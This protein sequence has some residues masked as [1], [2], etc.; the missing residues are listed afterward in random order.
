MSEKISIPVF[1][2]KNCIVIETL[3]DQI[4]LEENHLEHKWS[5]KAT[6]QWDGVNADYNFQ[7]HEVILKNHIA[8]VES[9]YDPGKECFVCEIYFLNQ[10]ATFA[11]QTF[12]EAIELKD[13]I[14]NWLIR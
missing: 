10:S 9:A 4:S 14:L 1:S 3:P 7:G 12:K 6:K 2:Y 11:F 8:A 5:T 13:K